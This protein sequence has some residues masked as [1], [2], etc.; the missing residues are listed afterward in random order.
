MVVLAFTVQLYCLVCMGFI[1]QIFPENLEM[2]YLVSL[3]E[4]DIGRKLHAQVQQLTDFSNL[5]KFEGK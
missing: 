2:Q 1:K 5:N 4:F 3:M